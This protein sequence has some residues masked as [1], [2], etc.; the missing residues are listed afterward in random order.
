V[1]EARWGDGVVEIV[2]QVGDFVAN[3]EPLIILYNGACDITDR[4]LRTSVAFGPER[5]MEQDPMFAFRILVDIALKALSP[6]INDPTT[7]VLCIDQVHRLLRV[8]GGR[9]LRGEIIRDLDRRPR[10]IYRTPN[11]EDFVQVSCHEIRANGAGQMQ[12]ARRLRAMLDNLT[13]TLPPHRHPVLND[14]R[15]RLDQAIAVSYSVPEDLALA[16]EPDAQGL[17][18]WLSFVMVHHLHY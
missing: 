11:W 2:P 3:G 16:R 18:D 4:L 8:V 15:Q 6:A 5:T 12:I 17:G 13:A 1:R 9:H 7:A 10:V 14:E